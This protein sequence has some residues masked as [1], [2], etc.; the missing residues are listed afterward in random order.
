MLKFLPSPLIAFINTVALVLNTIFWASI[1]Y[2]FILGKLI[3]PIKPWRDF[4]TKTA[5]SLAENWISTNNLMFNLTHDID[6]N[7][8][9]LD[10]LSPK[11]WYLVISNHQ[12]WTDIFVLQYIFNRK[13][14]FLKFFIKQN[15]IWVPIIGI[16]WWGLD[17]PFM[18]RYSKET[19]AKHPELKGKDLETTR[20]ACEKFKESPVSIMNFL[21]GTRYTPEKHKRQ[22]GKYGRLLNPKAGG[23]AFTLSALNRQINTIL[24]V[25]IA[26]PKGNSGFWAFFGGKT[27]AISIDIKKRTIPD[28]FLT[29]DYANDPQFKA[30]FQQYV[31]TLWQ[32]KDQTLNRLMNNP[33]SSLTP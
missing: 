28:K 32:E 22:R 12:S 31:S 14:P 29:G 6:W 21:E 33:T 8:S 30:D 1:M 5:V 18:K 27:E 7:I 9:G 26:Y 24:D 25:T 15:L 10:G 17:F 23:M 2:V 11:A 19:L 3:I 20:K 13:I 16:A 4:C